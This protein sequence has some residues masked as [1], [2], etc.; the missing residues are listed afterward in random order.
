[1]SYKLNF[2]IKLAI[3]KSLSKEL[4]NDSIYLHLRHYIFPMDCNQT[5]TYKVISGMRLL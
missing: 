4:R 3:D 1:M 2:E 5:F